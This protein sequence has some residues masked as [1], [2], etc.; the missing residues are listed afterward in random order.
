MKLIKGLLVA[1]LLLGG[2]TAQDKSSEA[3]TT[4]EDT[5]VG[6]ESVKVLSPTGAPALA[7]MT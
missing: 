2:C 7:A 1:A 4:Q 3:V 5:S 6:P